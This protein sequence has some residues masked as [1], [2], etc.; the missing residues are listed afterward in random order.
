MHLPD[1]ERE[2]GVGCRRRSRRSMTMHHPDLRG[3]T[4]PN[5]PCPTAR[6]KYDGKHRWAIPA[7]EVVSILRR[8]WLTSHPDLCYKNDAF[9]WQPSQCLSLWLNTLHP[10]PQGRHHPS[11]S[12]C[13]RNM[14]CW[15]RLI[16]NTLIAFNCIIPGIALVQH[17]CVATQVWFG[18]LPC[19]PVLVY[20]GVSGLVC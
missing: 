13:G 20:L 4:E 8:P 2:Y 1:L 16:F 7:I 14:G 11:A 10:Q 6:K 5:N 17:C 19:L 3:H 18:A 9:R 12:Q 15:P